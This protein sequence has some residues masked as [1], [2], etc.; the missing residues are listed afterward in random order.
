L[1]SHATLASNFASAWNNNKM[2]VPVC[3]AISG[4]RGEYSSGSDL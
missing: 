3:S 1:P 2:H 4:T